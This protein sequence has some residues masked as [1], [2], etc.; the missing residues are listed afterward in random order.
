MVCCPF[1]E[2]FAKPL[3]NAL[4]NRHATADRPHEGQDQ[5]GSRLVSST[6]FG[7]PPVSVVLAVLCLVFDEVGHN[8]P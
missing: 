5:G 2:A 8:N 1:E 3:K 6:G 4:R 7:R